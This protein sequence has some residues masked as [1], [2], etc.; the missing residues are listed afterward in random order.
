MFLYFSFL[1]KQ[2]EGSFLSPYKDEENWLIIKEKNT[3]IFK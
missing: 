2:N 3:L 1:L